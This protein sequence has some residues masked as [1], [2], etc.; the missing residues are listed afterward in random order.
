MGVEGPGSP[1]PVGTPAGMDARPESGKAHNDARRA[2]AALATPSGAE[3][4]GPGPRLIR[5]KAIKG[6]DRPSGDPTGRGYSRHPGLAGDKYRAAPTLT[7]GAA[8]VLGR[9]DPQSAPEHV[10][11][12]RAVVGH[13]DRTS[14]DEK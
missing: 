6:G 9:G 12:G 11:Q 2:E 13:G 3:G 5:V 10:K 8:S 1:F 14:I 7:L 4:L